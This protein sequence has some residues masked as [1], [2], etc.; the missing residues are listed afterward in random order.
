MSKKKY[1]LDMMIIAKVLKELAEKVHYVMLGQ[2][3]VLLVIY[4]FFTYNFFV[5]TSTRYI[6]F[7]TYLQL[8]SLHYS[9]IALSR[10]Q[11]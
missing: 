10:V 5:I 4:G 6:H 9:C 1:M 8:L 3:C 2:N 7:Y 11:I